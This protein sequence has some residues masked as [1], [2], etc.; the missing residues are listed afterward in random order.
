M[1]IFLGSSQNWT[2][3]RGLFYAF[4]GLFLIVDNPNRKK[5]HIFAFVGNFLVHL[6]D[7]F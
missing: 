1:D 5:M 6:L 3:L 7:H 4:K 2:K